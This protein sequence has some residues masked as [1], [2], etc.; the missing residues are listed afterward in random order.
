[1]VGIAY[2]KKNKSS[3]A[4]RKFEKGIKA[5]NKSYILYFNM[6][7][8]YINIKDYKKAAINYGKAFEL[9]NKNENYKHNVFESNIL[10][11]DTNELF[12]N[13]K[14]YKLSEEEKLYYIKLCLKQY[15]N[16]YK[17]KDNGTDN[18][19]HINEILNIIYEEYKNSNYKKNMHHEL[20]K[21]INILN[22]PEHD[23]LKKIISA[24]AENLIDKN[25]KIESGKNK[26]R[27]IFLNIF[28]V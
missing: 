16:T 21:I 19:S 10:G 22:K 24:T 28:K 13:M 20:L 27:N 17:N 26:K 7:N 6:A 11:H 4:I 15:I 8:A 18:I 14:K 3:L 2:M 5:N 25:I 23:N 9:N 1:M 12:A